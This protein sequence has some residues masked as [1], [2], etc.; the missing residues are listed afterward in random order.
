MNHKGGFM[1]D[2][3]PRSDEQFLL[4][5]K[6][7]TAYVQPKLAAFNIP[8]EA[9]TPIQTELTASMRRL[10]PRQA[11][12]PSNLMKRTGARRYTFVR[13]GE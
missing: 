13:A 5:A 4:W 11:P 8:A 12:T 6:T 7:L 2:Y 10:L 9:L 1:P 3:V